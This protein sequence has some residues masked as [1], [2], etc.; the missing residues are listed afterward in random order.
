MKKEPRISKY[1]GKRIGMQPDWSYDG[2]P[3]D[4]IGKRV[5]I[6]LMIPD[7]CKSKWYTGTVLNRVYV[8]RR[9]GNPFSE[10]TLNI[11][12]DVPHGDEK[13]VTMQYH[14][15]K[16]LKEADETNHE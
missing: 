3:E 2:D 1:T 11:E 14:Y 15:I 12:L 5:K 10:P 16:F 9:T 8:M 6:E 13:Q 4:L 7:E